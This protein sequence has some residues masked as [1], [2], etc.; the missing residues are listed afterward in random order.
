[1]LQLDGESYLAYDS[2][3]GTDPSFSGE[4]TFVGGG[5]GLT[6]G[7][8]VYLNNAGNWVVALAS[9][10]DP[11][12]AT[13]LLGIAMG[14]TGAAGVL[15]RGFARANSTSYNNMTT[16]GA[17][18]YVSDT[19]AGQFTQTIPASSGDFVRIIGY[20]INTTTDIMYFCPDNTYVE[21]T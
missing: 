5:T 18:L 3:L 14:T 20:V 4:V 15:L 2:G 12:A 19:S 7:N 17:K 11:T 6:A 9:S 1:L 21:I 16:R 8:L 10:V 13:S